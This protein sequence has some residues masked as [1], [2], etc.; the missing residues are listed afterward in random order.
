MNSL[1]SGY[2]YYS[3]HAVL[4]GFQKTGDLSGL[5]VVPLT[6][7]LQCCW[8]LLCTGHYPRNFVFYYPYTRNAL[9]PSHL[10]NDNWGVIH[11]VTYPESALCASSVPLQ[12]GISTLVVTSPVSEF[13]VLSDMFLSS[14]PH[15]LKSH[16][17]SLIY[18]GMPSVVIITRKTLLF[19][20][21]VLLNRS[22]RRL[23]L[24]C[25]MFWTFVFLSSA[26]SYCL[27]FLCVWCVCA[28]MG[29]CDSVSIIRIF[30]IGLLL[31]SL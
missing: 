17:S 22:P 3:S 16:P 27:F 29:A 9:L 8:G 13:W 30:L 4:L 20:H 7:A 14:T 1:L 21:I 18:S 5:L 2:T 24:Y 10:V 23:M 26:R 15:L 11:L 28:W 12:A 25:L 19:I 31:C 6:Y